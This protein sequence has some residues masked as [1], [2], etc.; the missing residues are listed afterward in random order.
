MGVL[1]PTGAL[2]LVFSFL[3]F[4]ARGSIAATTALGC[5]RG[6]DKLFTFLFIFSFLVLHR[7]DALGGCDAERKEHTVCACPA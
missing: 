5:L 2:R 7:S 3:L 6:F 1:V 4:K